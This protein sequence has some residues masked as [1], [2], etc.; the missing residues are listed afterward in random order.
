MM[1]PPD[2]PFDAVLFDLDGT[3]VATDR[4]WPEAARIGAKRAFAELGLERALPTRDEWMSMVGYAIEDGFANVFPDLSRADR[5]RV[6]ACCLAEEDSALRAGR[7]A[8]LPGVRDALTDLRARGVRL[9][10]ASNCARSYLDTMMHEL[11]LDR[12]IEEGRCLDSPGAL[13]K[14]GMLADLLLTFGTRSAV[15]VGDRRGDRDAAWANG[16]PHVHLA[17][18]YAGTGERIECEAT[19]EGMDELVPRLLGRADW[20]RGALARLDPAAEARSIGITGRTGSGKSL[21]ARDLVRSLVAA[22]RPA[23]LCALDDFLRP[24]AEREADGPDA[25]EGPGWPECPLG[26][27]FDI[28]ALEADVLAPHARGEAVELERAAGERQGSGTRR[29]RVHIPAGATLVLE[30]PC[31]AH[32]RLRPRIDRVL[33]LDVPRETLVRRIAGRAARPHGPGQPGGGRTHELPAQAAF[34]ALS[35]VPEG[36]DLVLSAQNALGP[37]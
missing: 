32:P 25:S 21:F 36:V 3:L 7:A 20:I 31:L 10:I 1:P 28:D 16:L 22:G 2:F 35:P 30:G 4:F 37:A 33:Y 6:M 27:A 34:E 24:L 19:I 11:G 26:R 8:T 9:G 13:D 23:A 5:A 18:G 12:W 29:A 17:R 15:M 14:A